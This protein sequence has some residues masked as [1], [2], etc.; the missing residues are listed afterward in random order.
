MLI[1][2]LCGTLR[3]NPRFQSLIA[4]STGSGMSHIT[5]QLK[6]NK[7]CQERVVTLSKLMQVSVCFV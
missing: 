5:L 4:Q 2:L 1:N 3:L 6:N 7:D